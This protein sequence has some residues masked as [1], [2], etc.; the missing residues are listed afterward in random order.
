MPRQKLKLLLK[1]Y[2]AEEI[3]EA[4]GMETIDGLE[5]LIIYGALDL[6]EIIEA[7]DGSP[8]D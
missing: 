2:S 7:T 1:D 3:M 4:G 8:E 6:D 5:L